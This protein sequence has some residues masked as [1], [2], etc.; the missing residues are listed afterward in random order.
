MSIH[1]VCLPVCPVSPRRWSI[2]VHTHMEIKA[3]QKYKF[4]ISC[5]MVFWFITL[6]N[7]Y[8]CTFCHAAWGKWLLTFRGMA[9]L[10][11]PKSAFGLPH[12]ARS[13]CSRSGDLDAKSSNRTNARAS[14]DPR[15][16]H[17][18]ISTDRQLLGERWTEAGQFRQ[19]PRRRVRRRR[20]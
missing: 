9:P 6:H 13:V 19:I 16:C 3:R 5:L 14:D 20:P 12:S 15:M 4:R 7:L 18:G 10:R 1:V 17:H 2:F 8:Y 11:P